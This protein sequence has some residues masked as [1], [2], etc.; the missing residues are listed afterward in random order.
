MGAC[1]LVARN[2]KMPQRSALQPN[3]CYLSHD[4]ARSSRGTINFG[5]TLSVEHKKPCP[6][7]LFCMHKHA[8][9]AHDSLLSCNFHRCSWDHIAILPS[10][11]LCLLCSFDS[12]QLQAPW[13]EMDL[14]TPPNRIIS[15][16]N[17]TNAM[18]AAVR[19]GDHHIEMRAH[20]DLTVLG[21]NWMNPGVGEIPY[22][23]KSI[24]ACTLLQYVVLYGSS[25]CER[26]MSYHPVAGK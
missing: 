8:G 20:L 4:D 19:R 23:V 12:V 6:L 16:V 11:T 13:Q 2:G 24:Q 25:S 26:W 22:T 10:H 21:S 17:S 18:L 14:F 7:R 9:V 3:F 15:V 1:R 5:Y